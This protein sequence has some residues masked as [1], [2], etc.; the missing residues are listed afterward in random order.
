M[1]RK[2]KIGK[3]FHGPQAITMIIYALGEGEGHHNFTKGI[4]RFIHIHFFCFNLLVSQSW[5]ILIETRTITSGRFKIGG[6]C[7]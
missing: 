1:E 7:I 4:L 2:S 3:Q 5:Q 6:G